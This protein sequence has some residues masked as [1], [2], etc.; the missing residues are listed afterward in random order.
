MPGS[1]DPAGRVRVCIRP[2]PATEQESKN[3][4]C[5]S[6]EQNSITVKKEQYQAAANKSFLFDAIFQPNASQADI[7]E[8][9]GKPVVND[10]LEGF[11]GTILAYGQTGTGKTYSLGNFDPSNYGI[12]PR[13]LTHIFEQ[14]RED[15]EYNITVSLT[16]LQLYMEVLYDLLFPDTTGIT[17]REDPDHGVFVQNASRVTIKSAEDCL[18]LIGSR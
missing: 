17:I 13:A 10:V 5:L 14:V 6:I 16:Y 4:T 8:S 7:Y 3:G 2:R 18:L 12:I 9:V 1:A 15:K 11:N